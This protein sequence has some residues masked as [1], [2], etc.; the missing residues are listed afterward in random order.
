MNQNHL[1]ARPVLSM[2]PGATLDRSCAR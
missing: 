2:S 1:V